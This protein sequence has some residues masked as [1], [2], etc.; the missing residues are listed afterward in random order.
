M[1]AAPRIVCEALASAE[2]LAAHA[3]ARAGRIAHGLAGTAPNFNPDQ[4]LAAAISV[5]IGFYGLA[6]VGNAILAY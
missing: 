5:F 4:A 6:F 2:A 1:T 3:S